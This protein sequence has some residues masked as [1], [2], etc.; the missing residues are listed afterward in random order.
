MP[1]FL[2]K[3]TG[4]KRRAQLKVLVGNKKHQNN[5]SNSHGSPKLKLKM[6]TLKE[7]R[8]LPCVCDEIHREP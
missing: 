3:R 2:N 6:F 5:S 8:L 4:I 1:T 7:R